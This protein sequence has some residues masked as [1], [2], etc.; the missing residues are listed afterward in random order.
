MLLKKP[1]DDWNQW[2]SEF[3]ATWPPHVQA[4]IDSRP[5][6]DL[7]GNT[8]IVYRQG[9]PVAPAALARFAE[10]L[11]DDVSWLVGAL[12]DDRRWFVARLAQLAGSVPEALLEPMVTSAAEAEDPSL[13]SLL[14]RP[15]VRSFGA[16]RVN[17]SL[18]SLAESADARRVVGAL[19][20]MYWTGCPESGALFERRKSFLL[21]ACFSETSTYVRERILALLTGH[22]SRTLDASH[23]PA[24]HT[25][26]VGRAQALWDE[27]IRKAD[28]SRTSGSET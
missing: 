21:E 4:F 10:L 25:E 28:E 20:A 3:A 14:I 6:I 11:Q 17:E 18:V 8:W 15:C 7:S 23:F 19:D 27:V 12:Q 22:G 26:L 9:V 13:N 2:Y 16:Q 1:D 24:S 5:G